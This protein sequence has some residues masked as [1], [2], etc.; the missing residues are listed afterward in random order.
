MRM[1]WSDKACIPFV[2]GIYEKRGRALSPATLLLVIP[3]S[4]NSEF[5]NGDG[6]CSGVLAEHRQSCA[7]MPEG[8]RALISTRITP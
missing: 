5:H 3:T 2:L 8:R 7:W 1:F 4:A 6:V